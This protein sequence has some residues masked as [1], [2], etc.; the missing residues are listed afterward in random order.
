MESIATVTGYADHSRRVK[1]CKLRNV[2]RSQLR[3]YFVVVTDTPIE[4]FVLQV[5]LSMNKNDR[6][7]RPGR[8]I[9]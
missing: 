4:L 8:V 6:E 7:A 2:Q 9:R 5:R 3:E 1:C